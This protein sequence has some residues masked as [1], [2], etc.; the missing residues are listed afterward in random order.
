MKTLSGFRQFSSLIDNYQYISSL[1]KELNLSADSDSGTSLRDV[2]LLKGQGLYVMN[3]AKNE[4]V[5]TRKIKDILGYNSSEFNSKLINQ[6]LFHPKQ[7]AVM[8]ILLSS[9]IKLGVEGSYEN[10]PDVRFIL[11]YKAKHKEGHYLSILRQTGIFE[12]D[13][14]GRMISVF[15]MLTDVTGVMESEQVEWRLEGI[16]KDFEAEMERKMSDIIQEVFTAS[17]LK[18]LN[19][20]KKGMTTKQIATTLHNSEFT[21]STH[22]RNMLRKSNSRNSR[23]LLLFAESLGI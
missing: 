17:E 21:I 2:V 14:Q 12:K 5:Y 6:D 15:S 8:S 4:V 3:Y 18:V 19:L 7:K 11:L 9:A 23:E 20:L 22:R 13:D 16:N 1:K 10:T